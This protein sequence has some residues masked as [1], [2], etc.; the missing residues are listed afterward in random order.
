ML[1]LLG[2]CVGWFCFV[3][4]VIFVMINGS[5]MLISPRAWFALPGWLCA[6][7]TL[8]E[9]KYGNGTGALQVRVLGGILLGVLLYCAYDSIL[10]LR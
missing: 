10:A 3:A 4:V 2:Q 6:N 9:T 5:Y 1:H 8:T 7:G